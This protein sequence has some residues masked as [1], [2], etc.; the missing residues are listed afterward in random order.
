MQC[1]LEVLK[2]HQGTSPCDDMHAV[3]FPTRLKLLIT[4]SF[5]KAKGKGKKKHTHKKTTNK[6]THTRTHARTHAH[7]HT[8]TP[9]SVK[10]QNT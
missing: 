10:L 4:L 9:I 6:Q 2:R 7:T 5:E 3:R 8:H 1:K